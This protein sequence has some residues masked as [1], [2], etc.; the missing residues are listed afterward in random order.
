[1]HVVKAQ[2]NDRMAVIESDKASV[3]WERDLKV[4]KSEPVKLFSLFSCGKTGFALLS[5][6]FCNFSIFWQLS[7]PGLPFCCC[8]SSSQCPVLRVSLSVSLKGLLAVT[9]ESGGTTRLLPL[10][11]NFNLCI[12]KLYIKQFHPTHSACLSILSSP[13]LS[14]HNSFFIFPFSF[15]AQTADGT[16]LCLGNLSS[17]LFTSVCTVQSPFS[18]FISLL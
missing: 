2:D 15:S 5:L 14:L 11:I 16:P 7:S 3:S 1:M 4:R 18:L 12:Y 8:L 10:E 13:L 6:A 9:D 17:Y